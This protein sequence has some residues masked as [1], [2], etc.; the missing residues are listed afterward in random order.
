M[1]E[2]ERRHRKRNEL[3]H[4]SMASK[5]QLASARAAEHAKQLADVS[6]RAQDR[7]RA[8][9]ERRD[10]QM[11]LAASASQKRLTE[12]RESRRQVRAVRLVNP[13]V[14]APRMCTL[15]VSTRVDCCT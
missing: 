1:A 15:S 9:L 4:T 12:E 11:K 3:L 14:R 7:A 6:R 2:L 8:E 13:A 10:A 5:A